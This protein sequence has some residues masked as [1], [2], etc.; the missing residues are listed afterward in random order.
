MK[1]FDG[2][3]EVHYDA[4]KM[5]KLGVKTRID[6]KGST[7]KI[8]IFDNGYGASVINGFMS[9]NLPELAVIHFNNWIKLRRTKSKRMKKKMLKQTGGY[10]VTYSTPIT[11]DVK[12]YYDMK[13]L[14]KD[15]DAISKLKAI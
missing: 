9:F 8:Y 14:T 15:L 2:Y 5:E 12:R 13:E 1:I 6:M 3:H 11:N 7:Q 4:I 10:D